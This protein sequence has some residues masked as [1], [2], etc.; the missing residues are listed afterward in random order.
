[1]LECFLLRHLLRQW[2]AGATG[3]DGQAM[4]IFMLFMLMGVFVGLS[5]A[6]IRGETKPRS[7][8]P[9]DSLPV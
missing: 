2:G 4:K 1:M 6:P 7:P 3:D 5:F 9:P 8:A